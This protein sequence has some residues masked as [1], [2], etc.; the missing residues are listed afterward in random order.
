MAGLG[1]LDMGGDQQP[2]GGLL[3]RMLPASASPLGSL[4]YPQQLD[5]LRRQALTSFGANI[6][7]QQGPH[8]QGTGPNFLSSLGNAVKETDW[9][10]IL[11][12]AGQSGMN[13]EQLMYKLQMMQRMRQIGTDNPIDPTKPI[14][15]QIGAVKN[16]IGQ[17]GA[18]DPAEAAHFNPTLAALIRQQH[19]QNPATTQGKDQL[20][21][22]GGYATIFR[23]GK[24]YWNANPNGS[25][26]G[27]D[28]QKG[29]WSYSL[30]R[31]MS[32]DA[33]AIAESNRQMALARMQQ[34]QTMHDQTLNKGLAGQFDSDK[35]IQNLKNSMQAYGQAIESIKQ[36]KMGNPAAYEVTLGNFIQSSDPRAQLRVQMFNILKNVDPSIRGQADIAISKLTLGKLPPRVLDQMQQLLQ[37]Q[38]SGAKNMYNKRYQEF[39]GKNPA[40]EPYVATPGAVFD[41]PDEQRSLD[42]IMDEVEEP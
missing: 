39:V 31:T 14:E 19:Y 26:T 2:E 37:A 15:D 20:A 9:P 17:M 4:L 32:E 38:H 23:P 33:K 40:A 24:G 35:Q 6:L 16:R 1:L 7:A 28:G 29:D 3:G 5:A 30:P 8:P 13:L 11:E 42:D 12:R 21:Q 36:A 25:E 41:A 10:G 22:M 34:T 27:P 18:I